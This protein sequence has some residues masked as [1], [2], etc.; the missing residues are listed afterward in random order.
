[1]G[2]GDAKILLRH[3]FPSIAPQLMAFSWLGIGIAI[4][5]EAALSFLGLGV[6]L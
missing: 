2:S 4:M 3:V 5:V 1:M 6:A